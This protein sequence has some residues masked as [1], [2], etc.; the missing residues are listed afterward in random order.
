M[1]CIEADRGQSSLEYKSEMPVAGEGPRGIM[2]TQRSAVISVQGAKFMASPGL[3]D[4]GAGCSAGTNLFSSVPAFHAWDLGSCASQS[5]TSILSTTRD[6]L[7]TCEIGYAMI[8]I[9][10]FAH[11]IGTSPCCH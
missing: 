9:I 3:V 11:T 10:L 2:C 8:N 5:S 7:G 1:R 4:G 6:S